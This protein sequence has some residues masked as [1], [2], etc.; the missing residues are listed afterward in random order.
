MFTFYETS[1]KG[2]YDKWVKLDRNADG[3][4]TYAEYMHLGKELKV[5]P[6]LVTS[7]D[8]IYIYKTMMKEKKQTEGKVQHDSI[9]DIQGTK[10]TY[11][12]FREAVLKMSCLGKL[13]LGGLTSSNLPEDVKIIEQQQ[14]ARV[15][16][17]LT[18]AATS[19]VLKKPKD[20]GDDGNVNEDLLNVFEKEFDVT[21]MTQYTLENMFKHIGL[22]ADAKLMAQANNSMLASPS[23]AKQGAKP[24]GGLGSKQPSLSD[25]PFAAATVLLSPGGQ[26]PVR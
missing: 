18:G 20:E 24:I 3:L 1:L 26:S 8:Y 25:N 17:A 9:L 7:Q 4:L 15:K 11:K 23:K 16:Q 21:E 22:K 5:Y 6:N 10:L 12:E 19:G 13:K 14:K 2:L